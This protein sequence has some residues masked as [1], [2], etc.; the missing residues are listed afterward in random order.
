MKGKYSTLTLPDTLCLFC[1]RSHGPQR[2]YLQRKTMHSKKDTLIDQSQANLA[3]IFLLGKL[4]FRSTVNWMAFNAPVS[5]F[6]ARIA[7]E[8][9]TFAITR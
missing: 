2:D 1:D 5:S 6:V 4:G 3:K 9:P 7:L 8:S